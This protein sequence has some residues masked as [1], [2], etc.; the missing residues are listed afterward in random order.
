[1]GRG[2]HCGAGPK[3]F[4]GTPVPLD[5]ANVTASHS[6]CANTSMALEAGTAEQQNWLKHR[7]FHAVGNSDISKLVFIMNRN[8]N[9]KYKR[10]LPKDFFFFKFHF[11]S[12]IPF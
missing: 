10:F 6:G 4:R 1:M 8:N 7:P 12:V 2:L 5:Q 3:A 9:E 11:G